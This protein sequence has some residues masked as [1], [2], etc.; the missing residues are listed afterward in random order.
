[1][2]GLAEAVQ[3][4]WQS[5]VESDHNIGDYIGL[6]DFGGIG[7]IQF[8]IIPESGGFGENAETVSQCSK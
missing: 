3:N 8:R 2:T 6:I 4:D 1:M 5:R 7:R